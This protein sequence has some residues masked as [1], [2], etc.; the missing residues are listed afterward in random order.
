MSEMQT[1]PE[2]LA[3]RLDRALPPGTP[4]IPPRTKDPLVNTAIDLAATPFPAPSTDA[5]K[6][7]EARML[8]A[9]DEQFPVPNGKMH[10]NGVQPGVTQPQ[11]ALVPKRRSPVPI[12]LRWTA[13]AVL[14]LVILSGG[15]T[16]AS[17]S[18]VP[19]DVLYPVKRAAEQV[20]LVIATS[21]EQRAE[22]FLKQARRRAEEALVLTV[23]RESTD[24]VLME[25]RQNLI[26]AE[27]LAPELVA[28]PEFAQSITVISA[29]LDL[30]ESRNPPAGQ[31]GS[32]DQSDGRAPVV[33]S[34]TPT[35]TPSATETS[36]LSVTNT[37]SPTRTPRT[38]VPFANETDDSEDVTRTPRSSRTPAPTHTPRPE[39]TPATAR[40]THV[41]PTQANN[42]QQS[43]TCPGN[44]CSAQAT[45]PPQG[46]PAGGQGDNNPPADPGNGNPPADPGGGNGNNNGNAANPPGDPPGVSNS[47]GGN[48]N[49]GSGNNNAGGNGNGGGNPNN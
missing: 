43:T 18:S 5:L 33:G 24:T 29:V 44:S 15:I 10:T 34:D 11:I 8:A 17:A 49:A 45:H 2:Q 38:R 26:N 35:P 46:T 39:T 42:G 22:V 23:R 13:A 25:A 20:E 30:V 48:E 31:A 32:G 6:R 12:V 21:P 28:Q 47:G 41:P 19:G 16:A 14:I 4:F 36:T 37:P 9:Y 27:Q 7:M 1:D 40:P 3:A